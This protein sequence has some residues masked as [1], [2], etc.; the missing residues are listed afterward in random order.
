MGHSMDIT[1]LET[2]AE[3]PVEMDKLKR[4]VFFGILTLF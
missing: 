3:F 2:T 4:Y 1:N